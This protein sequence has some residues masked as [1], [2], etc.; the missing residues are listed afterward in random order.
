MDHSLAKTLIFSDVIEMIAKDYR[1]SLDEARDR[2]YTSEIVK[3]FSDDDLG[4]YGES[5]LF[6]YSLYK[7]ENKIKDLN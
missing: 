7:E 5:P 4:L 2:F 6:V 3:L 1:V